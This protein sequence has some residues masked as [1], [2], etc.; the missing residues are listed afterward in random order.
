VTLDVWDQRLVE[1]GERWAAARDRLVAAIVDDVNRAYEEVSRQAGAVELTVVHSWS[2]SLAEAVAASRTDDVRRGVS[3]TG[4][5]RDDLAVALGGMPARTHASQGEQRCLA[6]ALKV[7]A[8][9][10]LAADLGVVPVLVLD[11]VFSELDPSRSAALTS[12]LPEGQVIVT[13]AV[14]V[15]AGATVDRVL[16]V[17]PGTVEVVS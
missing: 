12:A 6:L 9:R 10:Y 8:H 5:H 2:G 13:S 1:A 7:A 17:G 14:G 4:P 3:L 16:R 15:P 11:D